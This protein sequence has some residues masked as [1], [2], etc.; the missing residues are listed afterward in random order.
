MNSLIDIYGPE[1]QSFGFGSSFSSSTAAD[2]FTK[3]SLS[4]DYLKLILKSL[5]ETIDNNSRQLLENNLNRLPAFHYDLPNII[6]AQF[7]A[8]LEFYPTPSDSTDTLSWDSTPDRIEI[9]TPLILVTRPKRKFT[10]T[11]KKGVI[12]KGKIR[13][14]SRTDVGL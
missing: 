7:I 3:E 6:S 1:V 11:L 2:S 13:K 4:N 9:E 12:T 5:L 10:I 14:I 8:P